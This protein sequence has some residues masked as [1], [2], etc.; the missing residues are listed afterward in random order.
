VERASNYV[1]YEQKESL[2]LRERRCERKREVSMG[3]V[4]ARRDA[5]Y[6]PL[7]NPLYKLDVE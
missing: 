7:V 3:H 6:I 2:C 4:E 1:R 5:G